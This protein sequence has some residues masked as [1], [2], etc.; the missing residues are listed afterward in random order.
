VEED[1]LV[2][3][4]TS[5]N[6]S[7][8][9]GMTGPTPIYRIVNKSLGRHS[10]RIGDLGQIPFD[11]DIMRSYGED[12]FWT[13]ITKS[14]LEPALVDI[15]NNL[16]RNEKMEF[17]LQSSR[18]SPIPVQNLEK[19]LLKITLA[20]RVFVLYGV[21]FALIGLIMSIGGND[22]LLSFRQDPIRLFGIVTA[23]GGVLIAAFGLLRAGRNSS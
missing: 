11:A 22:L 19:R 6:L 12:A 15:W 5:D 21:A 16:C 8:Q 13:N 7:G 17:Q 10:E 2:S 20:E 9:L 14:Y 18:M 3:R 1:D 23:M 4:I